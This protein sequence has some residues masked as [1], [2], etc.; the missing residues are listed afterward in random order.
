MRIDLPSGTVTF[1]FTDVEGSTRLLR[2]LGAALYAEALAEHRRVIREACSSEGGVEVDTQG[3]PGA[4]F[5]AFRTAP[6]ALSAAAL[7]PRRHL[8]QARSASGWGSTPAPP[9]LSLR[10]DTWART[11]TG[12]LAS[13]PRARP[14]ARIGL[15]GRARGHGRSARSRRPPAEGPCPPPSASYQLGTAH[16]SGARD[17]LPDEPSRACHAVH[18]S[19]ARARARRGG[20]LTGRPPA[21][22]AHRARGNREDPPRATGGGGGLRVVS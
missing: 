13:E 7:S 3:I 21:A 2:S 19:R 18:R 5:F 9:F 20:A 15:D 22:D 8:P 10:R 11:S 14:G 4:F 6:G 12:P 16:F 1:L 17:A